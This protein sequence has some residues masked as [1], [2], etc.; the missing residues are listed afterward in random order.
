MIEYF[1]DYIS[2]ICFLCNFEMKHSYNYTNY[3]TL[4]IISATLLSGLPHVFVIFCNFR[5]QWKDFFYFVSGHN[6]DHIL[7][8]IS[9]TTSFLEISV[10][11]VASI[12]FYI[13]CRYQIPTLLNLANWPHTIILTVM[14]HWIIFLFTM[15]HRIENTEILTLKCIFPPSF[16]ICSMP[17][18]IV[19]SP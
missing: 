11:A 9:C 13:T 10:V 15:V 8:L 3:C 14:S 4:V 17:S 12:F 1:I 7:N 2:T 18:V 16:F 6:I 5:E 19:P